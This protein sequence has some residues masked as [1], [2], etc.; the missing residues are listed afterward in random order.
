MLLLNFKLAIRNL[1][2][3]FG[4]S[5]INI[6][7]L[8]IGFASC[9]MLLLYVNYEWSYDK[10]FKEIDRIYYAKLNLKLN[11][12]LLTLN[13]TPVK[14]AA[15]AQNNIPAIELVSR[16]ND[17]KQAKLFSYNDQKLKVN[18][19]N[20]DPS[21]LRIFD[22]QFI[23]G[24]PE[25]ALKDPNSV[26]LTASTANKLFGQTN[27]I[28]KI[29]KWDNSHL[30][31][32][33]AVI[34]D[35]PKNQS[36][37]FEALQTWAFLEQQQP[38]IKSFGW[39]SIDCTTI[40]QLKDKAAFTDADA[41]MRKLIKTYDENSMM[42]V[43]L[44]PFKKHHLY[45]NFINGK[46]VGGKIEEV[47]LFVLLAFCVLLI[48]SI[49]YMNLS[50]ARSEKR[51]REVGVRKTLGSSRGALIGQFLVESLLLSTLAMVIAIA[52]LELSLPYF[53]NLLSISIYIDYQSFLYWLCPFLLIFITGILAGSYPSFYLSS[54]TPVKVLKGFTGMGKSSLP[55]R[56]VLVVVQFGLSICM[57]ICSIVI[58]TQIK[59]MKDKPLGFNQ[60]NLAE[61]VLEGEMTHPNKVEL[62]KKE[63][64]AVGAVVSAS[65]YVSTFTNAGGNITG[66]V[67][68]PGKVETE[69]FIFQYR[70]IG[71]NFTET[72]GAKLIM[73]RDISTDFA[74]DSTSSVLINE[75]ALK[76][77]GLKN[78]IGTFIYFDSMPLKVVGVLEDSRNATMTSKPEATLFYYNVKESESL[79]LK[80][81]P[82]QPIHTSVQAIIKKSQQ[83]N[84]AYP[85]D[86]KFISEGMAHKLERENTL[87]VLSNLFGMFSILISCLGLLGLA[88]FMAEQRNKEISIRKVLGA[89]LK[90]ILILLNKDFMKLVLLSNLIAFPVAYILSRNWLR[91][92][93]DS[94]EIVIWP[95]LIAGLLSVLIALLTIS[96]QSFKLA[97]ANVIDALK[98]E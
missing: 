42:D 89:D 2:K 52:L 83:L 58:Y 12:E 13:A 44:F 73:G 27:P 11:G 25:S 49:N 24:S 21:F 76:I 15:A 84:P 94:V 26:L 41:S 1:L 4:F 71:Y 46:S 40:I 45:S 64:K 56:K 5:L 70:S 91:D 35:L 23:Y 72:V 81:N 85:L 90:S 57:I 8:S 29:L 33:T 87:G 67:R 47:K 59:H 34:A 32:V 38:E 78:P 93:D 98:Y 6:V 18:Y 16:M 3:N 68:W 63:L 66:D 80:L 61:V 51:A 10:Q 14:L 77:M 74:A 19:F 37:Q 17:G 86:L 7:G 82:D 55:V 50:T 36:F 39:G 96:L 65:E 54:F 53:N 28:G 88:L 69:D 20:V 43:F 97:K 62:F 79:L 30:L 60:N 22:Y 92:F 48:A 31:K 95:Y 75:A 9:L